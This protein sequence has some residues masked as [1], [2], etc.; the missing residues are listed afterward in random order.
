MFHKHDLTQYSAS[1]GDLKNM[2]GLQSKRPLILPDIL[3]VQ[4]VTKLTGDSKNTG[5]TQQSPKS[6]IYVSR[7]EIARRE[8]EALQRKR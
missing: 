5:D 2:M 8:S 7:A 4:G 1:I 3:G 6:E